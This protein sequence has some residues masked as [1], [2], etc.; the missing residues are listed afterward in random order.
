MTLS[1]AGTQPTT[2]MSPPQK[3]ITF[4]YTD[5][6][7]PGRA[8]RSYLEAQKYNQTTTNWSEHMKI[9]ARSSLWYRFAT[10]IT[11]NPLTVLAQ[12]PLPARWAHADKA[13]LWKGI[14]CGPSSTRLGE[15]GIQ[16]FFTQLP[17]SRQQIKWKIKRN[18]L[19]HV[20]SQASFFF[21]FLFSILKQSV[22]VSKIQKCKSWTYIS[23]TWLQRKLLLSL[24]MWKE[25]RI[26]SHS[27]KN[28]FRVLLQ[29]TTRQAMYI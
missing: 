13:S 12:F 1:W 19:P 27:W 26:N 17:C 14:T 2:W 7:R 18:K 15:A 3:Q 24:K 21:F 6:Q 25:L 23:H 29:W 5:G 4:P 11:V 20:C 10:N 9:L 16:S 22:K 8:H 28:K